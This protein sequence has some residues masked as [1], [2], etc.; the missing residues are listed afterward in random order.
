MNYR[1]APSKISLQTTKY[2]LMSIIVFI[3]AICILKNDG[4][5]VD[6]QHST[7]PLAVGSVFDSTTKYWRN[8]KRDSVKST[9]SRILQEH[10]RRGGALQNRLPHASQKH[11][12][13]QSLPGPAQTRPLGSCDNLARERPEM[14]NLNDFVLNQTL[15]VRYTAYIQGASHDS[16]WTSLLGM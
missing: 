11:K 1:K 4:Y 10:E 7:C 8:M 3:H 14:K 2:I 15:N 9:V 5:D 12:V 16:F 13:A 6:K